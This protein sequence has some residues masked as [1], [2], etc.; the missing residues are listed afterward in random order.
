MPLALTIDGLAKAY[1]TPD[2]RRLPV[3]VD[4]TL[5]VPP[6]AFVALV[7]PSGSGKSTLFALIAGLERPDSG[8]ILL[9]GIDIAGRTGLVGYMPQRDLLLPWRTLLDNAVLALD[10]AGT[11][12]P[13]AY[14]RARAL[15]ERF[16]LAG[17]EHAYPAALSG[18]M[19]QRAALL[20]TVLAGKALLLL[21]EP[22]GALDALTRAAMQAWLLD[23]WSDL[24]V[25]VLFITHDV[26]EALFLAD[27]VYVLTPRPARVALRLEVML[28]RPRHYD[29]VTS[30]VFV[31][32]KVALLAALHAPAVA[33]GAS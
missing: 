3:L 15:L 1:P 25:T 6:G 5:A 8:R 9:D 29:V 19:R 7:G 33:G 31:A 11:P 17:F 14:A 30:P 16:G 26:E 24:G 4:L 32:H 10:V 18:G 12:R 2:G 13:A 21:D 23:V 20:R 28:A 27:T 22:F